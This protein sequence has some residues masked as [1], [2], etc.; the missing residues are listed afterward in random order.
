MIRIF[1]MKSRVFNCVSYFFDCQK[2]AILTKIIRSFPSSSY[3]HQILCVSGTYIDFKGV[4]PGVDF[5][6][7]FTL[8]NHCRAI[9]LWGSKCTPPAQFLRM[10]HYGVSKRG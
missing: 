6:I 4:T 5:C 1:Y 3:S 8:F 2:R 9:F 10:G 7:I